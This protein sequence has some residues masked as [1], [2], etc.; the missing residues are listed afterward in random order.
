MPVVEHAFESVSSYRVGGRSGDEINVKLA[1]T[2]GEHHRIR[3]RLAGTVS[4][5]ARVRAD[6]RDADKN[7][8]R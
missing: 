6:D 1:I 5:C 8:T 2:A 7:N 3:K 4:R